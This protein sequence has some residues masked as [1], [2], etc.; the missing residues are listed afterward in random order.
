MSL[1]N[2]RQILRLCAFAIF[3]LMLA[4]LS[5]CKSDYPSSGK[6]ASPDA[7][8]QP[9]QV[10]TA[11]V[12]ELPIGETVTVNGNL[13][14]YDRTTVGMKVPGR[15]QTITVDLGGGAKGQVIA[16]LRAA[17]LLNC[18]CNKRKPRCRR[19]ARASVCRRM[20]PMIA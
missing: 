5:A 12:I 11:T 20:A 10:K 6:A 7:K 18:A 17:G 1:V 2:L 4:G 14:A 3:P 13:A 19:R 15:L 8:A 9:R 16:Q